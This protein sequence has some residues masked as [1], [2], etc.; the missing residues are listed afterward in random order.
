MQFIKKYIFEK[1]LVFMHY[2]YMKNTFLTSE[3]NIEV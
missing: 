1:K 3:V 2:F